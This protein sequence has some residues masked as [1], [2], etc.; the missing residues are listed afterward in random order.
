MMNGLRGR[1]TADNGRLAA[2]VRKL[3]LR[4]L[5]GATPQQVALAYTVLQLLPGVE[6]VTLE[7]RV[8]NPSIRFLYSI[9]YP[10]LSV[11]RL[12]GHTFPTSAQYTDFSTF[13]K[14]H[15]SIERLEIPSMDTFS[16]GLHNILPN[17]RR[18]VASDLDIFDVF[19]SNR[20]TITHLALVDAARASFARP[21]PDELSFIRY[22]AGSSLIDPDELFSFAGQIP[23]LQYLSYQSREDV[24][25]GWIR[26]ELTIF[27]G[28]PGLV[29]LRLLSYFDMAQVNPG[30]DINAVVQDIFGKIPSLLV[31]DFCDLLAS[32]HTC[33]RSF[34]KGSQPP[35]ILPSPEADDIWPMD[36]ELE[37][38]LGLPKYN[39][40]SSA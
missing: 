17:L 25:I 18:L 37:M 36:E 5:E 2:L 38:I 30:E 4:I 20:P 29:Y 6:R 39:P 12:V 28:S 21:T 26:D 40:A 31:L 10:R 32:P 8:S 24:S 16:F 33:I 11:L 3:D 19:P 1:L 15:P 27:E 35:K 9:Q 34:S 14:F 13:L 22:L 23:H 7:W